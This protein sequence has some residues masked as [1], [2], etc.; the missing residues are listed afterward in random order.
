MVDL[1]PVNSASSK[2]DE[3]PPPIFPM[4]ED[5]LEISVLEHDVVTG[6]IPIT[7]CIGKELKEEIQDSVKDYSVLIITAPLTPNESG[8]SKTEWRTIVPLKDMMAYVTF[9]RP[10]S[11]RIFVTLVSKQRF[12]S[13][14][15]EHFLM[16]RGEKWREDVLSYV[17]QAENGELIVHS[18]SGVSQYSRAKAYCDIDMP[19]ECFA[20]A[21]SKWLCK[22]VNLFW[23]EAPVDQCAFRKRALLAFSVQPPAVLVMGAM[24]LAAV[25]GILAFRLLA[26]LF[27][28]LFA[29]KGVD[30]TPI[31][32]P[33]GHDVETVDVWTNVRGSHLYFPKLPFTMSYVFVVIPFL[34][35]SCSICYLF[36][37]DL[38]YGFHM[39]LWFL[40]SA[41]I[42]LIFAVV[43]PLSVLALDWV[44]FDLL[45]LTWLNDHWLFR[46]MEYRENR[47]AE[48]E[49]WQKL[50]A[51][52]EAALLACRMS[53][54][55][56]VNDLPWRKRTLRLRFKGTKAKVCRPF[57]V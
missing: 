1:G 49:A 3:V 40:G 48:R 26:A 6:A 20:K 28:T 33:F 17:N 52:H 57:P 2:K 46:W 27:L 24:I 47:T 29:C 10:G 37:I 15:R 56:K 8:S 34:L 16:R 32:R 44:L 14:D 43:F 25:I 4:P 38:R 13:S 51:R 55:K 42:M 36:G 11:N 53:N 54:Y 35:L 22:W 5:D 41:A 30:W 9:L 19:K 39:L 12:D 50:R 45:K 23:P 31:Y 21:P 7:W 18:E